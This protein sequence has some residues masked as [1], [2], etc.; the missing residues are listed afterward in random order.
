M[1]SK[2]N[3]MLIKINEDR[4]VPSASRKCI[5]LIITIKMDFPLSKKGSELNTGKLSVHIKMVLY[6]MATNQV[7]LL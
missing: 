6:S 5:W 7:Y 2:E 4:L 3:S 1:R